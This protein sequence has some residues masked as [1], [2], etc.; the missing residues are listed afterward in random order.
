MGD[1]NGH[2]RLR[3]AQVAPL[4]ESVPPQLYGGTER[5]VSYLTE[6]L[7]ALG[8]DVTLFASGDSRT[9]AELVACAP[10]ALRLDRR[11]RG[12]VAQHIVHARGG[13]RARRR[14]RRHPLPRRLPRTSRWRAAHAVAHVTTLHGRLDMPELPA[15]VPDV[16][17]MPV[18]SI[19]DAQRAPLPWRELARHRVP[20]PA[21]PT[22]YRSTPRPG[23]YLAF[24][25][26]DLAR[27]AA[28]TARS[29]SRGA[30]ACRSR[31]PPRSTA[32]DRGLL[33]RGEIEPLL[34]DP[35]VEFIGEIGEARRTRSSADARGAAVSDRLAR[36]VRPGDDRGDGVRHAG[37]RLPL[38]LG[39]GG[40]AR[41]G[42]R[43]SS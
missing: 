39:P 5:V 20:R 24:L 25:G 37:G 21:R 30:R 9:R 17:A 43:A 26:P 4:Y 18:V 11:L 35:R 19:S 36:A 1:A 16:R 2:G 10:R 8:H 23:G 32:S 33:R 38:R 28:S 42:S 14:V 34:A 22:C 6:E 27:E 15:A 41:T 40:D 12:P 13:V 31:S 7:V 3:I 29:R